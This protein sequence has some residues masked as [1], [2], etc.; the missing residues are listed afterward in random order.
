MRLTL[1]AGNWGRGTA[2]PERNVSARANVRVGRTDKGL[3]LEVGVPAGT[4]LETILTN[5]DLIAA[6]RG[7]RPGRGCPACT[8][9][10]PLH[11]FEEFEE[12]V[13]VD[14]DSK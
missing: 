11:I 9:G 2:V 5:A 10:V 13:V 6:V 7:I 3:S 4:R 1:F 12:V 14:L 8:S